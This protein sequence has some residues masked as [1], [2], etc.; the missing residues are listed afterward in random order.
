MQLSR[1]W[2]ITNSI[3]F[4]VPSPFLLPSFYS[5]SLFSYFFSYLLK[6]VNDLANPAVLSIQHSSLCP[7]HSQH[8]VKPRWHH[9]LMDF[10]AFHFPPPKLKTADK[11]PWHSRFQFDVLPLKPCLFPFINTSWKYL[12][13]TLTYKLLGS[14]RKRWITSVSQSGR[15]NRV[16]TM[17]QWRNK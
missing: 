7:V 15:L 10:L 8:R 14:W 5:S 12:T 13:L 2:L 3:S 1:L 6:Y 11:S 17:W 16:G 9:F 4:S